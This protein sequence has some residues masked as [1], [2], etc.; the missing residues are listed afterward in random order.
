MIVRGLFHLHTRVSKDA[1]LTHE[2]HSAHARARGLDFLLFGEHRDRMTDDE[3]REAAAR[4]DALSTDDLLLVPGQEQEC[5]APLHYHIVGVGVREPIAATE[6]LAVVEEIRARGGVSVLAH[7]VRYRSHPPS[8][9]LLDAVDGIE[10]FNLRY[11]GHHGVRE[12]VRVRF[13]THS[14][15]VAFAGL[16]AHDPDDLARDGAPVLAVEVSRLEEPAL[17]EALRAGRFTVERDGM[18]VDLRSPASAARRMA[19]TARRGVFAVAR[20]AKR[21]LDRV[22]LRLPGSWVRAVR[23]RF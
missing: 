17:L 23:R 15:A 18:P 12:E 3:V 19:A 13:D 4:C 22:G 8:A 16:D 7:P 14:G 10:A 5:P 6:P 1:T 20:G 11:D 2:E 21:G 9:E